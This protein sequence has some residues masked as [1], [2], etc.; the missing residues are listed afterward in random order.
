VLRLLGALDLVVDGRALLVGRP[1]EQVVLAA[2]ALNANRATSVDHLVEAVWGIEPPVSARGQIQKCVYSLRKLFEKAGRTWT[3]RTSPP[4]YLLDIPVG[5]LDHEEFTR[6]VTLARRQVADGHAE[7]ASASLRA[8]LALWRGPALDGLRSDLLQ[9]GAAL[10]DDARFAAIEERVRLDL[11]LGRHEELVHELNGLIGSAPLRERLYGYR[12]LAM[13]RSGRQ[14]EALEVFRQARTTLI[15]EVGIE[16][17][18]E[19]REL[20]QA[21]LDGSPALYLRPSDAGAAGPEP[22][23]P[24]GQPSTPRPLPGS[25]ADFVGREKNIAAI[26]LMLSGDESSFAVRVVAISGKGGV[27]KSTLA[28]RVAHEL[29]DA[30]PDGHLYADLGDPEAGEPPATLLARFLRAL[31]VVGSALPEGQ[32]ERAELYRSLLAQKRL[33]VVLDGVMSEEQVLPL[34]PGTAACPVIITSQARLTG[35]S[36]ARWVDIDVL[37]TEKSLELL[38]KV[39][40]WDRVRAEQGASVELVHLCGGLPL[41]LRIVGGRLASAP[42][43]RIARLVRRLADET[44]RLDE[45]S[46]RGLELRASIGLTDRALPVNA[47]RLF[48]LFALVPAP[49]FPGWTAAALLDSEQFEADDALAHLVDAHVLDMLE[50][51]GRRIRYRF[52]DLIRLYAHEQ[53]LEHEPATE[54]REALGRVLG[55]WLALAE[56]AHRRDHGG[57]YTILHGDASRWYPEEDLDI[58]PDDDPMGWW[59]SERRALV[60]GVRKAAAEGMDELCWDLACTL[61]NLFEVKGYFD[62]WKET[63][64]LALDATERA[65]NRRGQAAALYSLGSLHMYQKRLADSERYLSCALEMFED[66]GNALGCALVLRVSA[67]VDRLQGNVTVMLAKYE[68]ALGLMREV[69]DPVGEAYILRN[70][71]KFRTDEGDIESA[72]S[73]LDEALVLCQKVNYRRGEAQILSRFAELHLATRNTAL[74]RQEFQRVLRIVRDIG[75]RTGEAHVLYGL[76]LIRRQEGKLE[77][78][79]TTLVHA[80]TLS[81]QLGERLIEAQAHYALG[82]IELARG[83]SSAG[84]AHLLK[85]KPHFEELGTTVWIAKTL[86]LLAEIHVDEDKVAAAGE[87]IDDAE[88]LLDGI[89]SKEAARLRDQLGEMR[90]ALEGLDAVGC[91]AELL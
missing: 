61:Y 45:L 2:L 1:K 6:L 54:R 25:T 22:G 33:L 24:A 90:T 91:S 43:L 29:G 21:I 73:M 57:D 11:E 13:Y 38:A 60:S 40:G 64:L 63:A 69:G 56:R 74:A 41:A 5:E 26:K 55:G 28:L 34:L 9:R 20:E 35:L 32:Q 50:Y 18:Q 86:I 62:D 44:R 83:H 70:L 36:G 4:G 19:L 30:F 71:A 16:P 88:R 84:A 81:Q 58:N 78:A 75:D 39:V 46:H 68:R 89:E 87:E 59:E 15:E 85:A 17:G 47:R 42:H 53:L 72:R 65:G 31:G 12:M 80:L 8:A 23:Q 49:D 27:G 76:G 52:H 37:S 66:E 14:A 77:S 7:D 48:R 10:L 51:P 67:S 82:G 3:I 79:E